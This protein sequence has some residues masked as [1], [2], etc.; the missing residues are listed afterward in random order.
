MNVLVFYLKMD[1]GSD[2]LTEIVIW[3]DEHVEAVIWDHFMSGP[4]KKNSK[5][6]LTNLSS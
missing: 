2:K 5:W 6:S 4:V 1:D 3:K